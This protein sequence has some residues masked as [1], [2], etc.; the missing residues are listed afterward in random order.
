MIDNYRHKGMRKNMLKELSAK[1]ISDVQVIAAMDEVPRHLF[2]DNAFLEIAYENKAF[3]IGCGQTISHPY[4]VAFQ[5]Q[6]LN[7]KKGDKV[8]EI[9]TGCGYQTSVLT[10]LGAK[11]FSIERH[12]PLFIKT[13]A[14]LNKLNIRATL[15]YGDGYAGQKAFAPFDK[16]I[17]TAAAPFIPDALVEQL[18][19]NGSMIIPIGEGKHQTMF[20]IT[21]NEDG[22]IDKKEKGAFSFVPM[23]QDKA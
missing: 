10:K 9:G 11:V 19:I 16:I 5:S 13:K 20:F 3:P 4:T 15:F 17:V 23:L 1:G 8:L 12:R 6:M 21:K 14:L 2:L 22:T 7:I 18:A